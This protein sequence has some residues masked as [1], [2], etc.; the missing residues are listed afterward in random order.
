MNQGFRDKTAPEKRAI[1]EGIL[2]EMMP[3]LQSMDGFNLMDAKNQFY[4]Y[5]YENLW[6]E[7]GTNQTQRSMFGNKM[8]VMSILD[9]L[10]NDPEATTEMFE[11]ASV[12]DGKLVWDFNNRNN[13]HAK[14][15]RHLRQ[16]K[17]I[18]NKEEDLEDMS[19]WN[20]FWYGFIGNSGVKSV[21][22]L[23]SIIDLSRSVETYKVAKRHQRGEADSKDMQH[24]V[25]Y[26]IDQ[27]IEES[28]IDANTN[29]NAGKILAEMPAFVGEIVLTGGIYTAVRKAVTMKVGRSL[30]SHGVKKSITKSLVRPISFLTAT[31]AQTAANPGRYMTATF[32]KMTPQMV[33][34][35]SDGGGD[36]INHLEHQVVIGGTEEGRKMGLKDGDNFAKAFLKGFGETLAEYTTERMGEV[37]PGISNKMLKSFCKLKNLL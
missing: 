29:Y 9:K 25:M 37:L 18:I 7:A 1:L 21:P 15:M 26:S 27:A 31:A 32:D 34:M 5:F 24:L 30:L 4:S 2:K 17:R 22:F 13:E 33:F 35:Y 16:A 28:M 11:G 20:A 8:V 14:Y 3:T 6:W 12:K 19:A 10:E 36:L 23:G